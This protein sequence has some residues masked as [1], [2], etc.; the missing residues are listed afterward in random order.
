MIDKQWIDEDK[1]PIELTISTAL[2]SP[3]T[4]MMDLTTATPQLIQPDIELFVTVTV[5]D[6]KG[7]VHLTTLPQASVTPINN[8][9][10][11]EPPERLTEI[12]LYDRPNDDGTGLL[13]NFQLSD[14][15][16]VGSYE[17]YAASNSFSTVKPGSGGPITP[18]ATLDRNP[19][20]PLLIEIV[21]G[22]MPVVTGLEVWATVV[23]RDTSGNAYLDDLVVVSAQAKDDGFDDS[24]DYITPVD[25]LSADWV[26]DGIL[27]SWSGVNSGEI[28]GYKIYI[29]QESFTTITDA[30][31]VGEVLAS[32]NFLI[33]S[34]LFEELDNKTTWYVAVSPFDDYTTRTSVEV[35]EVLPG[36]DSGNA[37]PVDSNENTDFTSLL[38]TPNLLAV[39][40]LLVA[41]L[42][43]IGIIRTRNNNKMRNKNWELQEATWGI[44]DNMGWDD[45]P[46]FG[47]MA[48]IAPPPQITPQI[49]TN[50]YSAAQ[51]IEANDPYQ[52]QAYQPQQPVL[53]PQ[54]NPL[55][56]ELNDTKQ[57]Q[58]PNIDTSF[59]DDLL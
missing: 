50:L 46:E 3:P 1:N 51:R 59:L 25:D 9:V 32:T 35:V 22:D 45:A 21:A 49:E 4:S 53:Q 2:Y 34:D 42:L 44:Q 7:N 58:K 30:V 14:A 27:V 11:T 8:I 40:L 43:V 52:R 54:N 10:D 15:S 16:D 23:V 19:E 39:G 31:E 55:L 56:N 5:H 36:K 6:I 48:P 26:D 17:I 47:A 33:T 13:L 29:L 12:E 38:T 18:I 37:E 41:L 24:G 57:S 20:L 28:R